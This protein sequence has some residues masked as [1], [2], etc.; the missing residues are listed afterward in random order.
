MP[1]YLYLCIEFFLWFFAVG[2][3]LGISLR[4][5]VFLEGFN[6]TTKRSS[7]CGKDWP[8]IFDTNFHFFVSLIGCRLN[9]NAPRSVSWTYFLCKGSTILSFPPT[10]FLLDRA[11]SYAEHRN[12]NSSDSLFDPTTQ[13]Y[14][15]LIG[16][17]LIQ[18]FLQVPACRD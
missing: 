6:H 9:Q 7:I 18:P 13:Q 3:I 14:R 5:G 2:G 4:C 17:T 8:T 11:S 1:L 10:P 12:I 15:F 16:C